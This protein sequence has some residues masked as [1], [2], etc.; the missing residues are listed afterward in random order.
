[1]I[2]WIVLVLLVLT[3]VL[4]GVGWWGAGLVLYPPQKSKL[5]IFPEKFGLRYEKVSFTTKDGLTLRGWFIPS[6]TGDERTIFM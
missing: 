3:T 6:P 1:M 2:I 4:L 5:T